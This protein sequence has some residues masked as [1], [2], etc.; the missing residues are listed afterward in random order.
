MAPAGV[1]LEMLVSVPDALTTR[2]LIIFALARTYVRALL[3]AV[4]TDQP[5]S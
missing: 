4:V 2:P 1:E 3:V 5:K